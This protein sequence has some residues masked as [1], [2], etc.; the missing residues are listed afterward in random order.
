MLLGIGQFLIA[1]T[2]LSSIWIPLADYVSQECDLMGE[3]GAFLEI[4]I[5]F[6]TF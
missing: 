2:L 1:S 3:K 6:L 5:Q 4:A